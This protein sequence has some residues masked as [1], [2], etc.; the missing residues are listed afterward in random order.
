MTYPI[1]AILDLFFSFIGGPAMWYSIW[2]LVLGL[3][4]VGAIARRLAVS[5]D[6]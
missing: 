5:W 6:I 2:G 4:L 3:S 1:D